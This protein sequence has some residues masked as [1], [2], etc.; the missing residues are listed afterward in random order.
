MSLSGAR[1][2]GRYQVTGLIGRGAVGEVWRALDEWDAPVA[3]KVIDLAPGLGLDAEQRFY[4]ERDRLTGINH[5]NVVQVRDLLVVDGVRIGIVMDLADGGDLADMLG[6]ETL[7]PVDVAA[8]G[9]QVAYGLGA[10]HARG[11][12]HRGLRPHNV[13][14]HDVDGLLQAQVT[15]FAVQR[16]AAAGLVTLPPESLDRNLSYLA[17]ELAAGAVATSRSDLYALGVM[18][19]E[20]SSGVRPF[21]GVRDADLAHAHAHLA[22]GRPAGVPD[23]LWEEIS[24][25]LAKD[26]QWRPGDADHV[27]GR[28]AHIRERVV[29][30]PAAA[31]LQAP[32]APLGPAAGQGAPTRRPAQ[33]PAHYFVAPPEPRHAPATHPAPEAHYFVAAPAPRYAPVTHPAPAPPYRSADE[34]GG[35]RLGVYLALGAL[36]VVVAVVTW[37]LF[38]GQDG[39]TSAAQSSPAQSSPAQSSTRPPSTTT[40]QAS[41]TPAPTPTRPPFPSGVTECNDAL[42]VN[43]NTSCD[44]AAN[45]ATAWLATS[46]TGTTTVQASSPVTNQTYTMTCVAA[47][48]TV[49][50]GGNN[51]AVYIR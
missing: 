1:L 3:V 15:D 11:F 34:S 37:L 29:G 47:P 26:P 32:P 46:R 25:L 5:P 21:D 12:A 43:A 24:S 20:L 51:A 41:S 28:L 30:L 33:P 36:V 27:A 35:S 13:M 48:V 14:L 10:L 40:S 23:L 19:Y 39:T 38:G 49:C 22:P 16:L 31:R 45:V 2:D 50:T 7:P 44:F 17:P 4:A 8:V 42:G 6:R 9:G 18:L